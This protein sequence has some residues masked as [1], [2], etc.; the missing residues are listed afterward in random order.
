MSSPQS[1]MCRSCS[2]TKLHPVLNLGR[3]PLANA[4]LTAEQLTEPEAVYP[5]E[6]VFCPACTLVQI[7]ETVPPEHLFRE[8]FYLSSFSDTLLRHAEEIAS[9]I[10]SSRRL[11]TNSLV[12]E[13]ASNDGY[14]LQYYKRAGVPVLGIEPATNIARVAESQ[15]GIPTL[16]EFFGPTLAAE[17]S[18]T[19][20]RADVIHANN[21]LAHVADLNGFVHGLHLL[22][23]EDGCAVIEVPY[24]KD[25]IDRTEFDTIYHE[26]L[27]YF[28]L[29][30]LDR[31]FSRHNLVIQNVERLPIHGGTLRIFVGKDNTVGEQTRSPSTLSLLEEEKAWAVGGF[32]FYRGF[33]KK[34]ERLRGVLLTLLG[35]LKAQKNRIAVYGASAKGSTLLN[36]FGIGRETLEYVV[37]RS[38]AKQGY[39]TPGT[40]LPIYPPEH[41]LETMPD[42]V[43]LLT[44]NFADEILNQQSEY[45]QR[46]GRFIIPIPELTVV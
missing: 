25:M 3:T 40:H 33:G 41:L 20:K 28:S 30:A 10:S 29:T 45:R 43:L 24:V 18:Q 12:I 32:E 22:L 13:I 35:D 38:T 7:T 14:L 9:R 5:L 36:C 37:D 21:V 34:V 15:R 31:L 27:C 2:A 16:A 4:L 26:H 8:Y 1:P 19:G 46:G 6:L 39:Y 42:Y 17:L 23:K 44:W 11:D